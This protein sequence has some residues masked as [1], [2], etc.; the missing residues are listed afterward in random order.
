MS[1]AVNAMPNETRN[2]NRLF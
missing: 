2:I 1:W